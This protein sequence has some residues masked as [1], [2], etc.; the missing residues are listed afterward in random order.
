[1]VSSSKSLI[2]LDSDP[3]L[4]YPL[5]RDLPAATG[6]GNSPVAGRSPVKDRSVRTMKKIMMWANR[7]FHPEAK[8]AQRVPFTTLFSRFQKILSLNNRSLE[9]I[10]EANDKLGGHYVFDQ[11]YIRS[12][13]QQLGEL[14][15]QL[16]YNLEGLVP[17]KYTEL[18]KVFREINY[19]IEAELA[20]HLVISGADFVMPYAR[21]S[22]EHLNVVGGKNARLAEMK[23]VLGL[24]VPEGFAITARAFQSFMKFNGLWPQVQAITGE[25]HANRLTCEQA[26]AKIMALVSEAAVPMEVKKAV[27]AE[28]A[29]LH[30]LTGN[31]NLHLAVRSSA[32]GEDGELSFAG[33]YKSML[34]VAGENLFQC[35][36]EV[37]ASAFSATAME[38]RRLNGF[39]DQEMAMSVACQAMI[40]A[41]ISGVIYTIAPSSPRQD[42]MMISAAWGLGEPVVSGAISADQYTVS[43]KKPHK[44]SAVSLVRKEKQLILQPGGGTVMQEVEDSRTSNACL[45]NE[46]VSQLVTA[47][48]EIE[49]FFRSHMDIEFAIDHQGQLI[50][51]QA[52]PLHVAAQT[53]EHLCDLAGIIKKYPVLMKD[54]GVIAQ[55][56]IGAGKVFVLN[57]NVDLNFFPSGAIL[58]AKY[59]SP[60][61]A[62]VMNKARGIITD[63]GSA[64]CH[65]ATIAR[66]FRVPTIVNTGNATELFTTGQEVTIDAEENIIY[67]GTIDELCFYGLTTERLEETYEYRLLRRILKKIEPLALVDPTENNFTPQ[68]CRSFHD[69]IRFVHEKAVEEL[70]ELH[71]TQQHDPHALSGKLRW[72]VPLDMTLIDIGGGITATGSN[73]GIDIE[74][75]ASIPMRAFVEGLGSP[76]AWNNEPLSVDIGS[77]MSSLTRTFSTEL[78]S[79]R[80]VGQNLAVISKG[81][82]NIS[83]RLGYHFS[84]IDAYV[85]DSLNDNYI[86]FRFAGGVTDAT[87]RARR[88][89]FLQRILTENDFVVEVHDDLVI[90]RIKKLP[91][92]DIEVKIRLLGLLVGFTR[93]LDVLLISDQHINQFISGFEML[94]KKHTKTFIPEAIQ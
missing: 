93:Q 47:A 37:V 23:K 1:M 4:P 2:Y 54:Q 68:G 33:Q 56:G 81:Y 79:P 90:A 66:E 35:Y 27:Q 36:K 19:D 16:I 30:Q 28:L 43:R 74:Q 53:T 40:D 34:N 59:A 32:W 82:A 72:E 85:S 84:I 17:Q 78:S 61:Y 14:V 77:F 50:I 29:Q 39:G 76:G 18:Y 41:R 25:W 22:R 75:I 58:V 13:S 80:Y 45:T 46:Q 20:G 83:L 89:L 70:I 87:R 48:L 71:Y 15:H 57:N 31:K 38:Y 7:T 10:A 55:K 3:Y 51:L 64:T 5:M 44:I 63:V 52:R 11:Q 42:D 62:K 73:G 65:M 26:S 12:F 8:A 60:L 9:L 24:R 88:A 49:Q 21:I 67:Q 6:H 92:S 69:I 86:Y 94:V 91:A